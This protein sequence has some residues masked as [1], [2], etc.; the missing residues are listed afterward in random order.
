MDAGFI[1]PVVVCYEEE[2]LQL[3]K[4]FLEVRQ[5]RYLRLC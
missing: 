2:M 5:V 4:Q 3:Q 1:A